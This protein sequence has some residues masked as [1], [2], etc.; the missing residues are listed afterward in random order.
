MNPYTTLIQATELAEAPG[1][2]AWLILDCRFDLAKPGWGEAAYAEGHLPGAR[3]AHLDRDLSSPVTAASGRHPLPDP[4][5]FAAQ[6]GQWGVDKATQVVAYDQGNGMYA[7][8]AWWLFRWLGHARVAVLDGGL[9]AWSAAGLPLTRAVR[10]REPCEFIAQPDAGRWVDAGT[11]QR[12]LGAGDVR[13]ADA[14]GADRFA[15]QNETIDPVAGHV[16]GAINHPF[17][18]NLDDHGRFLSRL[19]LRERWN[20]TLDG[21]KPAEMVAMCGSGVSACHNLLALEHAGLPGARLYAGS[22][23]E[24]IRD[25]S[26]PVTTGPQ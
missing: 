12:A 24:W 7:A 20:A 13:L 14:R 5:Q 4:A 2:S 11:L 26:R 8:R 16:P 10:E 25:P 15:G 6:A 21:R 18:R 3:Y 23:S 19:A 17:T 9:A 22:W 1:R